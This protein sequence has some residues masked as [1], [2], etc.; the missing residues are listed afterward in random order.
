MLKIW[1]KGIADEICLK[2]SEVARDTVTIISKDFGFNLL[3]T[4][5]KGNRI[6]L[7][8]FKNLISKNEKIQVFFNNWRVSSSHVHDGVINT[9]EDEQDFD[10]LFASTQVYQE[11]KIIDNN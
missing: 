3:K 11:N 8:N 4:C 6:D 1:E 9:S 7:K 2:N 5:Q 10:T